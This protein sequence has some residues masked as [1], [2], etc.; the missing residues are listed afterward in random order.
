MSIKKIRHVAVPSLFIC[1]LA[2]G[3]VPPTMSESLYSHCKA[4]H[5]ILSRVP[6][7]GHNDTW[8]CRGYY[9]ILKAFLQESPPRN[10]LPVK[11][12]VLDV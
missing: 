3:F 5:K 10:K 11:S 2:D 7:G 12:I 8:M 9:D 4:T 1:G 6:G